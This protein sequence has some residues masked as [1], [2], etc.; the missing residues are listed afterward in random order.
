[1]QFL[2]RSIKKLSMAGVILALTSLPALR[3]AD[4]L[5]IGSEAP[6]LNVEHWVH[7]GH[8]KFKPVTKF[9]AGKVYVVE[10]WATWCGPCIASMPHLA[11]LQTEYADKGVQVISIS[12]EE[13]ETVQK[14]LTREVQS[15]NRP[16][17]K[18]GAEKETDKESAPKTYDELTSAYCLTTDPDRS[19]YE[20]Y[21]DAAKQNGIPTAFIVGK[22]SKIEWI[23][24]PMEMDEPLAEI[25]SDK[26]DRKKFAEIFTEKQKL[27]VAMEK[28]AMAVRSGN[29]KSALEMVEELI[30][31]SKDAGMSDQLYMMRLQL[32]FR[33][34]D[35]AEKLPEYIKDAYEKFAE[36][37]SVINMIAWNLASKIE[38]K[39][40][41]S[42][43]AS[44]QMVKSSLAAMEKAI[45]KANTDSERAAM[46]DTLAHFQYLD[47]DIDAAIKS[48]TE[49][50]EKAAPQSKPQ[51]KA[52][53]D[54][55]NKAKEEKK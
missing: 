35:S 39:D 19:V 20:S 49:A 30:A 23:G 53:L 1:M 9:S 22:D 46:L 10:F 50:V 33:D 11:Q 52:F 38:A 54:K 6:Q 27:D 34:K 36:R 32:R 40:T 4:L 41:A 42:E 51:I 25:V 18:E 7:D 37:G 15:R 31:T 48:Q 24:H 16:P 13:L 3:A 29:M 28:I 14:F 55:L 47:G 45:Q 8:G 21:M 44:K 5:T 2:L 12:D 17:A 43:E 26:W